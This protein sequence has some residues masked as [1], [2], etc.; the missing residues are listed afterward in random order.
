M[1]IWWPAMTLTEGEGNESHKQSLRGYTLSMD[2]RMSEFP[3]ADY[4]L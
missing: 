2:L 4:L 3:L 1:G